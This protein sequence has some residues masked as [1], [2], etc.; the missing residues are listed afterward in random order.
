MPVSRQEG[1][2]G[3]SLVSAAPPASLRDGRA[4][5]EA[6]DPRANQRGRTRVAIMDATRQLLR[7]G[8]VPSIAEAAQE[9]RV[10]RATAYRYFPTQGALIR[11]AV[12]AVLVPPSDWDERLDGPGGLPGRIDRLLSVMLALRPENEA[13]QRRALLLSLQQWANTQAG[14]DLG[15][16]PIKR[17]G[18]LRGI[19][20]ALKPYEHQ[21]DPHARRRLAIA[22][23]LLVG[24]EAHIVLHDIWHLD[25]AEAEQ[26]IRWT[27]ETLTQ[28]TTKH[29]NTGKTGARGRSRN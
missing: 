15:E 13:F 10:S 24:I 17:G 21:L 25:D 11:E 7:D 12:D 22:I 1:E 20:E 2:E 23:S 19:Q 3:P 29:R 14:E 16:E 28:A 8:K 5:R 9:A 18:R 6:A 26:I 4:P 27:A